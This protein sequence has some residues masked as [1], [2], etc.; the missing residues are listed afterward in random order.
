MKGRE[1]L[2]R[3]RVC[4]SFLSLLIETEKTLYIQLRMC[5]ENIIH[6]VHDKAS[7]L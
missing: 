7:Y 4:I 5:A 6:F 2:S 3:L 1:N